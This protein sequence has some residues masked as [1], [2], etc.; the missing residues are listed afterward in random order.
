MNVN[1][2]LAWPCAAL[3]SPP[4]HAHRVCAPARGSSLSGRHRSA[5]AAARCRCRSLAPTRAWRTN[6]RQANSPPG[7]LPSKTNNCPVVLGAMVKRHAQEASFSAGDG[8]KATAHCSRRLLLDARRLGVQHRVC[9]R[10]AR[11]TLR[12]ALCRVTRRHCCARHPANQLVTPC[13]R[14]ST[15]RCTTRFCC[16]LHRTRRCALAS[17][18]TP[19]R[20]RRRA[21]FPGSLPQSST[22]AP[23]DQL[24]HETRRGGTS[25]HG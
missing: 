21:S 1:C 9:A 7:S 16:S 20:R 2:W 23:A 12:L 24:D 17:A 18:H 13:S 10:P 5:I 8:E 6:K 19:T 25:A 15:T 4:L 3:A 22:L 11:G 14:S